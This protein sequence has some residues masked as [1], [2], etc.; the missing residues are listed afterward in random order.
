MKKITYKT[1][2]TLFGAIMLVLQNLGVKVDVEVVNTIATA[3]ASILV[4]LGII[5]PDKK[6][7]G[8]VVEGSE[9][10]EEGEN[11]SESEQDTNDIIV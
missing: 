3:V 6:A 2:M 1:L 4:A 9:I 5:L 7:T 8:Q 11:K 10:T